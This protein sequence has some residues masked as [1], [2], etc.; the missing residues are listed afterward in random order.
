MTDSKLLIMNK[1]YFRKNTNS[2]FTL[3]CCLLF[4]V[5]LTLPLKGQV[6]SD[7][8]GDWTLAAATNTITLSNFILPSGNDRLMAV[9]IDWR[10]GP[11]GASL[12]TGVNYN[13]ENFNLAVS[14]TETDGTNN[15]YSSIWYYHFGSGCGSGSGSGDDIVVTLN[16]AATVI[17]VAAVSFQNVDSASPLGNTGINS[18]TNTAS[19]NLSLA[20]TNGSMVLDGIAASSNSLSANGSQVQI[21]ATAG[22]TDGASYK[23]AVGAN[24]SMDWTTSINSLITAHVGVEFREC[25][26]CSTFTGLPTATA[27]ASLITC[28]NSVSTLD[29]AG[30]TTGANITYEWTKVSGVGNFVGATNGITAMVD[31]TG[32]FRLK[33]TDTMF[34][35]DN[36]ADVTVSSNTG[37]V[38]S[39][40]N[41]VYVFDTD[42]N[43][44]ATISNFNVP[45]GCDRIIAVEVNWVS[46]PTSGGAEMVNSV[47]FNGQNFTHAVT[48]SQSFSFTKLFSSIWYLPIGSGCTISG[49]GLGVNDI[50]VTLNNSSTSVLYFSASTFQNVDQ[51]TPLGSTAMN[52]GSAPVSSISI[53]SA[54]NSNM[55]IDA[56]MAGSTVTA[57]VSQ[58][59][60][61]VAAGAGV[62]ASY[63]MGTGGN[64]LMDWTQTST[65]PFVH[66]AAELNNCASCSAFPVPPVVAASASVINC[67]NATSTLDGTGSSTGA[68]IT[69]EW[70]KV[71]GVG[72]LVGATNGI[73]A[74]ADG[75][76]V[77]RLK[78]TNTDTYCF[79]EMDVAV[80]SDFTT[81]T[82]NAAASV[83]NCANL[84]SVLSAAGSSTGAN[85]AYQWTKVSGAGNLVGPTNNLI[86]NA[87]GIG[88][89]RV[90]VTNT[91]TGCT[92]SSD[93]TVIE[94]TN[95][96]IAVTT[97][98]LIG[99][100]DQ[101][102][103]L[104]GTGSSA[105]SD[106]SYS[107]TKVS[108]VGNLVGATNG[109]MATADGT[110]VFRLTVTNTVLSCQRSSD[111][112]VLATTDEVVSDD[113]GV[114][115][116]DSDENVTAT[117]SNFNVPSGCDRLLVV[118]VNWVSVPTSGGADMVNSITYNGQSFTEAVTHF[119]IFS[120]TKLHSSIWYLP[121]GSGCSTGGVAA[122]D[123]TV[124]LNNSTTSILY[125][126]ASSFQN[127]D[128]TS[129]IGNIGM[130]AGVANSS[131]ISLASANSSNMLIDAIMAGSTVTADVSQTPIFVAMGAGVGASYEMGTGGNVLMDWTQTSGLPFAHVAAELNN[132]ASCSAFPA[133]PI[134]AASAS[135]IDCSNATSTLDGTGSSTG[136]NITYGWTKISGVGNLVGATNGITTTADGEGVF[137]LRVTNTDTYCFEE[138]DVTVTSDFT[139]PIA[140]TVATN[141]TCPSLLATLEGA[142]SSSGANIAY[143]WTKV[144]GVGN[145]V[146]P[147]NNIVTT[148]DGAGV[149]KLT[150]TNILTGCT[151]ESDI[152]VTDDPSVPLAVTGASIIDCF[153]QTA[154][155]DGTG[156]S[157]GAN[158]TYSWTKVSGAG[159][160][161][162]ATNGITAT[163]DGTGVFRLTVTNAVLSCQRSSDV[164]V[165]TTNDEVV[166]DDNGVYEFDSDE[167][168]S[169]TISNFV[170]PGGCDRL[171]VVEVNWVSVPTSGGADM[172]NNITYKGQNF[173]EAVT[174][175]ETFSFTR[176]Y[177]SIWYL[178]LGSGCT[179]AGSAT[180]DIDITLNNTTT[181]I[182]YVSASTFQNVDQ[183]S[184]LGNIGVNAGVAN[185]SSISLA[186]ANSSNMLID[187]IMAGSTVMADGSQ[188]PIFVAMGA[189]VGASYEMGTG[190]NVMMDWTQTSIL[191]FA[192]VAAELNNC[193]ACNF[194]PAPPVI[195]A[196]SSIIDCNN[197]TST[198][199][200]AGSSTGANITYEWTKVSGVGNLVG[201]TNGITASADDIGVFRLK[202]TDTD[203]YCFEEMDVTV[204]NDLAT[205][206]VMVASSIINCANA[207][208]NLDGA[209]SST[210]A[211][212]Y[213]WTKVSGTGNLVGATNGITASADGAGVFRLTITNNGN[214][215]T[216][217]ADV[218]VVEDLGTP[219]VVTSASLIT[220]TIPNSTLDGTGSSVGANFT[221]S[222]TK[223]SGV[224]N[225]VGAT[226]ALTATTDGPGVFKLT[227][228]N[229]TNSCTSSMDVIVSQDA[230]L[231]VATAMASQI[232]CN[233]ANSVLNGTGS[234]IGANFTYSWTKISGV[235]NFV[236][237]TNGITAAVDGTG[238]FQINVTNTNNGCTD[239]AMVTVTEDLTNPTVVTNASLINCN[240][241]TSTLDG[242][243]S[244][245]GANF[246]YF[247]TK[248]SGTGNLT[249]ATNT[250]TA[251]VDGPGVFN[252][253]VTNT[254]NGCVSNS[255]VTVIDNFDT[256]TATTTASTITCATANSTLDGAGSSTTGVTYAW[257][258]VSG[259][260]NLV[261]ATNA[262]TAT[263]DGAGVFRLTVTNTLS[264]CT[265]T[266][267][268]TVTADTSIPVA[269]S[270]A[271]L[272]NCMD[273]NSTLDGT[274]SSTG[275]DFGY[276]WTKISGIGNLVGATDG[277]MATVNGTGI[278]RLT[279]MDTI[280]G[281]QKSSDVTVFST[282][283]QVIS[284]DNGKFIS[285]FSGSVTATIPNFDMP[286]GCDRILVVEVNWIST[287]ATPGFPTGADMVTSVTYN[288]QNFIEANTG[289]TSF[290]FTNLYSSI[291]YLPMGSGCAFGTPGLNDIDITLNNEATS[292]LYASASSFQNVDQAAPIGNIASNSNSGMSSSISIMSAD[293]NMIV[294]AIMSGATVM[295]DA[296][297]T[298]IFVTPGGGAGSSY[299]A[300]TGGMLMMDW[301]QTSATPFIQVAVELNNCASCTFFPN[302]P[303][304]DATAT[305]IT[306]A[307][308]TSTLDGTGSSANVSYAWTKV[309][310]TGNLTGATDGSTATVDGTGVFKLTVTDLMTNCTSE[311]DV[312]VTEDLTTPTA[313]GSS[314]LITCANP[315]SMLDGAGSTTTGVTYSWT[316][317]SGTGNIVGTT[318]AIT[319]SADG[320]GVFKLTVTKI[321]NGCT[322]SIDVTVTADSNVPTS[323][324]NAT[325]IDCNNGNATLD[326]TGSSTGANFNYS[327]SK[328]SGLGALTG[329]TNALMATVDSTGVFRLTVTNTSN[330][331]SSTTDVTVT[332]NKTA[333]TVITNA[334]EI[335]CNTAT[336]TLNGLGSSAGANFTYTWTKVSGTGNLTGAIDGVTATTDGTGTFRLM[337]MNTDNGC[338]SADN[339]DV[340]EILPPDVSISSQTNVGC[341]G[342]STGIATAT[343]T[344]GKAPFSYVWSSGGTTDTE[345]GFGIGMY[346]VTVTDAD[347]CT[348]NVSLTITQPD[349]I[350]L[351]ATSTFISSLGGNDGTAA[352]NQIGGTPPFE[353][354][355]SNDSTTQQITDLTSGYYTV[356]VTDMNNCI[357]TI[358]VLVYE[359]LIV[360]I[361]ADTVPFCEGDDLG[362]TALANRS[363]TY[364]WNTGSTVD[365][366][367]ANSTGIYVIT[368]TD[369]F[370]N[371]ATNSL[372]VETLPQ[373]DIMITPDGPNQFCEGGSV[374]L[375]AS[376]GV[377]YIWDDSNN[378]VDSTVT[379]FDTDGYSVT[380]TDANGCTNSETFSVIAF[381]LPDVSIESATGFDFCE[382][383]MVTLDAVSSSI[384]DFYWSTLDTNEM[385]IT[386]DQTTDVTLMVEDGNGCVNSTTVTVTERP[387]PVA[388]ILPGTLI[389]FCENNV[390]AID[391][392]GTGGVQYQWSNGEMTDV[393]SVFGANNYTVTVTDI[394]GCTDTESTSIVV[395]SLPTASVVALGDTT[396][397]DGGAVELVASGGLTYNWSSGDMTSN[398]NATDNTVYT[399]TVTDGNGCT[400]T[401]SQAVETIPFP[402][403]VLSPVD[404]NFCDGG[405]TTLTVT[406]DPNTTLN[407]NTGQATPNI[408]VNTSGFY[409]VVVTGSNNCS[410]TASTTVTVNPLPVVTVSPTDTLI[411]AGQT[412]TLQ[413]T[414]GGNYSWS[415]GANGSAINTNA[416]GTYMVTI[417]DMNG[418]TGNATAVVAVE[419]APIVAIEVVGD[420]EI[421]AGETVT[422]NAIAAGVPDLTYT[423][424]TGEM[425]QSIV[426]DTTG[427][428]TVTVTDGNGFSVSANESIVV[429]DLPATP[430][431]SPSND[432][433]LCEGESVTLTS[434]LPDGTIWLPGNI[435][436]NSI[437]VTTTGL[438][439][440]YWIDTNG[441]Q[442]LNSDTVN[443][444]V[445]PLP[446]APVIS[447]SPDTVV[448]APQTVTLT[449]SYLTGNMWTNNS[450]AQSIVIAIGSQTYSVVHTDTNG[451]TSEP[452]DPVSVSILLQPNASITIVG[453][454]IL[455]QDETVELIANGG[456]TYAWNVPG[457]VSQSIVVSSS[458]DYIVTVTDANGCE[459][460]ASQNIEVNPL[461]EPEITMVG[462]TLFSTVA[463]SYQWYLD[464]QL[465]QGETNQWIV[466]A[467]PGEYTVQV[468]DD[469][470]CV[471]TS[472][473]IVFSDLV[474]IGNIGS[475]EV[476]PVPTQTQLFVNLTLKKQV[477]NIDIKLYNLIGQ[478]VYFESIKPQSSMLNH[479]IDLGNLAN[480]NY[481][482]Q[483]EI[484]G[485][486]I[487]QKVIK[488]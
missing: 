227:V 416:S 312:T 211:V 143:A 458:G 481:Y 92:A 77:F 67:S 470:G 320:P 395:N 101:I 409:S 414:G 218:T 79:E 254:T 216:A 384:V 202:V 390:D 47:I 377:S 115:E 173:T 321:D 255:N 253:L 382:G 80:T 203:T 303:T 210:S 72:N 109:I 106:Y 488:Q 171:L 190:G 441:C 200:G 197:P 100:M 246:N 327:W 64:V 459:D 174:H 122:N 201:A 476:F 348:D 32:I 311:T 316:K 433:V 457:P 24:T 475:I 305:I 296:S 233:N 388:G 310:G 2:L 328:V 242:T 360:E 169:A 474:E 134:I 380:V 229:T 87:D 44:S 335:N 137:R 31:G 65:L 70:T 165:F 287:P 238:N 225:L 386:L 338:T 464:G 188:T 40:D 168:V 159:N 292:I 478:E 167:N 248:V 361:E 151:A 124:T 51:T 140:M 25:A 98:T 375:T 118:E 452:S 299:E 96:P 420:A 153:N 393:I 283:D 455:C 485:Q 99:C 317:V 180:S 421:C 213:A 126:S 58:T 7:G 282:K 175:F 4:S 142:G 428:Y 340:I 103:I 289:T 135:V 214:G 438:Y 432:Q 5:V 18:S 33:V 368:V 419:N 8:N 186:S 439:S 367:I 36:T 300:S 144:S 230:T 357:D 250:L 401:A 247:W 295:N 284:D 463:V 333:P 172:V 163:V 275:G 374:T 365:N 411:Q 223:V 315:N 88:V 113:N 240:N 350:L 54:S 482:L 332:E 486:R 29:G 307:N 12:V 53:P 430:Q 417:T 83:I 94:D 424:S 261:G 265:A 381:P 440:A 301:T 418:C 339:I 166:S 82:A 413:A 392:Q 487:V 85:I 429:F 61:F 239:V 346:Q 447:Y 258:K 270:T 445:V 364:K 28:A 426:V 480:G 479:E 195:A 483:L 371:T 467:D 469:N 234:S 437:D 62:G 39:D 191:P 57:D 363:V 269:V 271:S 394:F 193:A 35:C 257:T 215:C 196:T 132:C 354:L 387:L 268:V 89:Y 41:G 205:P 38:I 209:G 436:A 460:T 236:G 71:S 373:P 161:V 477:S 139:T 267:D 152:T 45:A 293:G 314:T 75:E 231:P 435:A 347:G 442:S 146:G 212:T 427:T 228:T 410:T 105:G 76:G 226:N 466:P 243:G 170:I 319:A 372:Y 26:T 444:Q 6:I 224:G 86:A 396:F 472:F 446:D 185:S 379:V 15:V 111:V 157:T 104:D 453:D 290:S 262:I 443:V 308:T 468:V 9:V 3:L 119:E 219:A 353:Y 244:S 398:I 177:S 323:T 48:H 260:G 285:D 50:E 306:C 114:Y 19:S 376:G 66:V 46:V 84:L 279:V 60:I 208:S 370:G 294:D 356:T 149:F 56:I 130:N 288:G 274:G 434:N 302:P 322:A 221:Y 341:Y 127:V 359:G 148:A 162:G 90:T 207:T 194:L 237:A 277:I 34:G 14:G 189:G 138:V 11:G 97:A 402:D 297:Q 199:D 349:S 10:S 462:D 266:S 110:G 27:A 107:W 343:T 415:N 454:T 154:T 355:W 412:V 344:N 160:L 181:S 43:V 204:T 95:V 69:Y 182:L 391:L 232:N 461:P 217:N 280:A 264:G 164:A 422:L 309:S 291:W 256:P 156:S 358:G 330:G 183:T 17:H 281:C 400:D 59:P 128:Q 406:T 123:I 397:C 286:Q 155:L 22:T 383:D 351:N 324:G 385:S 176:L 16:T 405:M 252:L 304:V 241:A 425:T 131:S 336:A 298:A 313:A 249:G 206:T 81:P 20:T 334:S 352:V 407:W 342:D 450:T 23:S 235:G 259:T 37:Q 55:L 192:H 120:F 423:W 431:I 133:P 150:V 403:V 112:T 121:L 325:V 116:F 158:I 187:A 13:G 52:A 129:P 102:S 117:I 278:F 198:L 326:G 399:V 369:G 91:T 473:P 93:V 337:V 276:V 42:E 125:A 448:C 178:P 484:E 451:C 329:A 220:C 184:P 145:L 331:C 136:A 471:G 30:S 73:I 449:S 362:L 404:T 318:D 263:A 222:W 49:G 273:S 141:V 21:F 245:V 179:I 1:M 389:E 272:I 408:Q 147:T 378:T 465:I 456:T 366:T 63:E 74:S 108:G 78:V 251:T 68:N 345:N